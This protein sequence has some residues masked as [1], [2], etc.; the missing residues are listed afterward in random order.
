MPSRKPHV[1]SPCRHDYC[2]GTERDRPLENQLF[3]RKLVLRRRYQGLWP[4]TGEGEQQHLARLTGEAPALPPPPAPLVHQLTG[5]DRCQC[6]HPLADAK[7]ASRLK[8]Q[9]V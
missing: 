1:P 3:R 7:R 4:V 9:C 8:R 6:F 5:P 2:P